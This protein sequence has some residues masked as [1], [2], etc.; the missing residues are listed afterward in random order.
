MSENYYKYGIKEGNIVTLTPSGLVDYLDK[1]Y[2]FEQ[3]KNT[4][5]KQITVEELEAKKA[6]KV[7]DTEFLNSRILLYTE[8]TATAL[9]PTKTVSTK[10]T[11]SKVL[12][13]SQD[14]IFNNDV[15]TVTITKP[16]VPGNQHR[17]SAVKDFPVDNAEQ[18]LITPSTGEDRNYVLPVT[19][20]IIA[21]VIFAAGVVVIKRYIIKK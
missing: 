7:G 14:L 17:G 21:L 19:I 18:V 9:E 10:L 11:T 8:S 12:T 16:A 6:T 2:A 13:T 20:G 3:D 4:D 1:N 15:E 5:W